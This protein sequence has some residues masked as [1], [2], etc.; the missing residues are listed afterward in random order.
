[1]QAQYTINGSMSPAVKSDWI[2]LYEIESTKLNYVQHSKIKLDTINAQGE[3]KE[4]ATFL[5]ELPNDTRIGAYRISYGIGE[6]SFV[7]FFYNKENI[8]FNFD[9]ESPEESISFTSSK[10]NLLYQESIA[11]ISKEQQKLDAIQNKVLQNPSLNLNSAY[12]KALNSLN[13]IQKKYIEASRGM[14]VHT[15]IKAFLKKN[16]PEII[17]TPQKYQSHLMT[18]FFN[19]IDFSDKKL[20]NSPVLTKKII[21]YLFSINYSE[22]TK[23]QNN[24]FKKSIDLVLSKI[25]NLD[26]KEEIIVFL[27]AKFETINAL[28]ILDYLLEDQYKKLPLPLQKE[29]FYIEKKNLLATQIGRMAPDFSWKEN[30]EIVALSKLNKSQYYLLVFWSTECSHCLREIPQLDQYLGINKKITTIA[31]SLE[32]NDLNWKIYKKKLPNWQHV[33]GEGKW[34]NKI[35]KTYNINATPTYFILDSTKNIIAKPYELEDVKAFI[36]RL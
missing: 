36:E 26:Y 7:D 32:K 15:F 11:L 17:T 1:I 25:T 5:F 33:F 21:E 31:I 10:E 9:P 28:K 18:T 13:S 24:L 23:T 12:K 19:H 3:K 20:I 2:I 6:G 30:G 29:E 14:Y 27:M 8:H 35:V 22:D 4:I 16:A 34:E